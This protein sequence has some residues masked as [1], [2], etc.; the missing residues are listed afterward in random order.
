MSNVTIPL[1]VIGLLVTGPVVQADEKLDP[2]AVAKGEIVYVRYCVACHGK[3]AKGDGPL[4]GD[5]RI[6]VPDLTRLASRNAGTYPYARVVRLIGN[7][8]VVRG[9][10]TKDMPAW[11]DVFKNTKGT[12]EETVEAAIR[13]LAHY[14][15]SLQR[16]T[17]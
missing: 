9:H 15:W 1:L 17:K 3:A 7:G 5:L 8:E 2:I 16:S 14:L 11:G 13:N 6:P 10:G 4:A 12:E